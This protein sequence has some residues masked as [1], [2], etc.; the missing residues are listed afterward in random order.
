MFSVLS[1]PWANVN[2]I[3][4]IACCG[5][6]KA[7]EIRNK[8][9]IDIKSHGKNLP[10]A[11]EKIVPMSKVMEFLNLDIDYITLM[12]NKESLIQSL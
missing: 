4:L 5:R 1:K 12:A 7:T 2:D 6:D 10:V 8:I 11:R 3:K 9:I